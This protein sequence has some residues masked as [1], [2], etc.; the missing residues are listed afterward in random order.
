[1]DV[2]ASSHVGEN[3]DHPLGT[4]LYTVSCMHCM[5]VSLAYGGEGLG[6]MWGVQKARELFTD[7]GFGKIADPH[8]RRRP[9]QQ[10][11]RLPEDRLTLYAVLVPPFEGQPVHGLVAGTTPLAYREESGISAADRDVSKNLGSFVGNSP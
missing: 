2:Q 8:R 3:V 4:F 11:L 1:M 10:L 9:V 7:A 6:A 5:T